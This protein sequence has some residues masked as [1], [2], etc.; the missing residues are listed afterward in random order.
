MFC[1][2][3]ESFFNIKTRDEVFIYDGMFVCESCFAKLT[4]LNKFTYPNMLNNVPYHDSGY[5]NKDKGEDKMEDKIYKAMKLVHEDL[6]FG[7]K[8]NVYDDNGDLIIDNPYTFK[9]DGIYDCNG[10]FWNEA[11]I[12][13]IFGD[14]KIEI[15]WKPKVGEWYFVSSLAM[16]CKYE[17]FKNVNDEHDRLFIERG[18]AFKTKEEA[19]EHTNKLIEYANKIKRGEV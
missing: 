2:E 5:N 4:S 6:E 19:I 17:E 3:C 13:L 7:D 11:F 12:D 18:L 1:R 14:Y 10:D 15:E 16:D 8:F 9:K